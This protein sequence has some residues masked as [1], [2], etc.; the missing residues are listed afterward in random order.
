MSTDAAH[1]FETAPAA[2]P[3]RDSLWL[4]RA[5]DGDVLVVM[6]H[7]GLA[8]GAVVDVVLEPGRLSLRQGERVFADLVPNQDHA[9]FL[10]AAPKLSVLEIEYGATEADDRLI[11]H[12]L[13]RLVDRT[14]AYA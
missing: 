12:D 8:H 11:H 4:S 13:A 7:A 2:P 9:D 1:A 5:E 14:G 3:V 6:E 10:S